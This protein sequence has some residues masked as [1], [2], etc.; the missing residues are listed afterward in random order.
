[1]IYSEYAKEVDDHKHDCTILCKQEKLCLREMRVGDIQKGNEWSLMVGV[2]E[3]VS[4]ISFGRIRPIRNVY[5]VL[6][7][8]ASVSNVYLVKVGIIVKLVYHGN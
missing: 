3:K 1:M 8:E 5:E 2:C 4:S 6:C 7:D